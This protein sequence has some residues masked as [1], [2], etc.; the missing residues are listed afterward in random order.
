[1]TRMILDNPTT[2]EQLTIYPDHVNPRQFYYLPLAPSLSWH[3]SSPSIKLVKYRNLPDD[4]VTGGLLFF[5][6]ELKVDSERLDL[7]FRALKKRIGQDPILSP[8][9]PNRGKVKLALFDQL[10]EQISSG[11][12][13]NRVS[14]TI[15]LSTQHTTLI[16][17]TL[18][19][20][21]FLPLNLVWDMPFDILRPA[22]R[23]QII[24]D[25]ERVHT[26]VQESFGFGAIFVKV[27]VSELISELIED[28]SV[29]ILVETFDTDEETNRERQVALGRGRMQEII[30]ENFFD[31]VPLE[32][33][34]AV[35]APLL[36]FSRRRVDITQIDQRSTN[37]EMRER[38]AVIR[39][40]FPQGLLKSLHGLGLSEDDIVRSI[41]LDKD[42]FKD[43]HLTISASADF[44]GDGIEKIIVRAKYSQVTK[45]AKLTADQPEAYLA[46][47]GK[48][49]NDRQLRS[50]N[51]T[52]VVEFEP[53][54]YPV[55]TL[56]SS[57]FIE[58]GDRLEIN[59]RNLYHIHPVSLITASD[60]PWDKF[61]SI[62]IAIRPHEQKRLNL[63]ADHPESV[64]HQFQ[65]LS[66]P[67]DFQTQI[68]HFGQGDVADIK[69]PWEEHRGFVY[70]TNPITQE[71][72][73]RLIPTLSWEK[74]REIIV[75]MI[76][77]DQKHGI[78]EQKAVV[79]KQSRPVYFRAHQVDP[80]QQEV[81]Y[82]LRFIDQN[83]FIERVPRSFTQQST[84]VLR[85]G[86][87]GQQRLNL[88]IDNSAF[89]KYDIDSLTL[90]LSHSDP[91]GSVKTEKAIVL[92]TYPHNTGRFTFA[93]L[94]ERAVQI[95]PIYTY[96]DGRQGTAPPITITA[97]Q[98]ELP[99]RPISHFLD[100]EIDILTSDLDWSL[101]RAVT[102]WL[103]YQEESIEKISFVEGDS[104]HPIQ[105]TL[106][107]ESLSTVEYRIE[108]KVH[109]N[110]RAS[111][112]SK[113]NWPGPE[114]T[115]W[116]A[117]PV[118]PLML[119]LP[120]DEQLAA[121]HHQFLV[122]FFPGKLDPEALEVR[123]SYRGSRFKKISFKH[124]TGVF[125]ADQTLDDETGP[126]N[127]YRWR[128]VYKEDS[129]KHLYPGP[130]SSSYAEFED[131]PNIFLDQF[132]ENKREAAA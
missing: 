58:E 11:F 61:R 22:Y 48:T 71:I 89:S 100:K 80:A 29:T 99:G 111:Y 72:S 82:S 84:L 57:S 131:R 98:Y 38:Q 42:F 32:R 103:R 78:F 5:D 118:G 86:M 10:F 116:E 95:R 63:S 68:T 21:G 35:G 132:F 106:A 30:L 115:D 13:T 44:V 81:E 50:I 24:A 79:I 119:Q 123:V 97:D 101:Y 52:Y 9:H 66:E 126:I 59:P 51:I 70:I 109:S 74:Y 110:R 56:S 15:P 7:V 90:H 114:K 107:D 40:V 33:P 49:V 96:T 93:Y 2:L 85:P 19:D 31:P 45:I 127:R 8:V 53:D 94:Q 25:W 18:F 102:I 108:A 92:S 47:A 12:G 124:G 130:R 73:V 6:A 67:A 3:G 28:R 62:E 43:R 37:L 17:N 1:M 113:L 27:E 91:A 69:R 122:R 16:A 112:G 105:L 36:G 20:S 87:L 88:S 55:K 77:R 129:K 26:A 46:W 104:L 41:D 120:N 64:W 128:A 76:Y 121:D 4:A 65:T 39:R 23:F 60:Y 75:D 125:L 34:K 83:G 117:V 14:F 54:R